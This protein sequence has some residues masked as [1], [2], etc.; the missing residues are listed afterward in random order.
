M[1]ND[2][3]RAN[4]VRFCSLLSNS[5]WT[6]ISTETDIDKPWETFTIFLNKAIN[7][8][9]PH[10]NRRTTFKKRTKRRNNKI[11]NNFLKT[12]TTTTTTNAYTVDTSQHRVRQ[13]N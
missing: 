7:I 5:E 10:R 8:C 2:H 13:I 4:F 1:D 12:S 6:E 11:Q 9:M 3:Q